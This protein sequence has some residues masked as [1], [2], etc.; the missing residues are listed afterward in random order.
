MNETGEV[1]QSVLIGLVV[2]S[3]FLKTCRVLQIIGFCK[4]C[5]VC[6]HNRGIIHR[7][8]IWS[9]ALHL[10]MFDIYCLISEDSSAIEYG[11]RLLHTLH[12]YDEKSLECNLLLTLAV[13][14]E[15]HGKLVDA[16]E[17]FQKAAD[18]NKEIGDSS[19]EAFCY[20]K[21]GIVCNSLGKTVKATE[22]FENALKVGIQVGDKTGQARNYSN[23]GAMFQSLGKYTKGERVFRKSNFYHKRIRRQGYRNKFTWKPWD[24]VGEN[25]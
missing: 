12:S 5:L 7:I 24:S 18:I 4:K 9:K 13:L 6:K 10:A 2:A 1:I 22:S 19:E 15:N 20:E 17:L 8:L 3:F 16:E 21:L 23:L 14:C 11:K 25:W